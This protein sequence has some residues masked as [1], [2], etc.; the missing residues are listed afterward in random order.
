MIQMIIKIPEAEFWT[1]I[2]D[3]WE[4]SMPDEAIQTIMATGGQ[5]TG[6]PIIH[7]RSYYNYKIVNY[8]GNTTVEKTEA[9]IDLYGLKWTILAA[10]DVETGEQLIRY[11]P[12]I[13]VDFMSDIATYNEDGQEISRTRPTEIVHI[14]KFAGMP[15]FEPA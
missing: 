5:F 14:G 13:L 7:T 2:E 6:D 8:C 12:D 3:G 1:Q 9:F 11:D 4:S 15:D 10:N